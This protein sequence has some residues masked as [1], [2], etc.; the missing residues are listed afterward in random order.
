MKRLKGLYV[1][2]IIALLYLPIIVIMCL[3]INTSGNGGAFRY[4]GDIFKNKGLYTSILNSITVALFTTIISSVAGTFIAIGIHSLSKKKRK[5][6]VMLNNIPMLNSEIVTG[7]SI[8]IVCMVISFVIPN[9]FGFWTMLIAHVFFTLPYVILSVLPKL[10][11]IDQ[12]LY[13][14][15]TDLGCS[16]FKALWKI[17]IPAIETGIITGALLSFTLS[18]DDFVI[19]YFTSGNGFTNFSNYIYVR[20]SRKT[21]SPAAYAFNSLLTIIML[22]VVLTPNL[23]RKKK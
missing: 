15:A 11:E 14:A 21:F 18:I 13:E 12:N 6:I 16:P 3:S 20:L 1:A 9:I 2:L 22:V 19:S 7:I 10:S 17:V 4:Y 5:I 23:R 8:M